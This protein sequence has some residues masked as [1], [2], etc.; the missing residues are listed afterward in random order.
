MLFSSA[1]SIF[2]QLPG[3]FDNILQVRSLCA[4]PKLFMLENIF[5]VWAFPTTLLQPVH[6]SILRA[7]CSQSVSLPVTPELLRLLD[8]LQ[9][10]SYQLPIMFLLVVVY[11]FVFLLPCNHLIH[12]GEPKSSVLFKYPLLAPYRGRGLPWTSYVCQGRLLRV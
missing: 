6:F 5:F 10:L 7:C 2:F 9:A 4:F 8:C 1:S 11:L 3:S 12:T